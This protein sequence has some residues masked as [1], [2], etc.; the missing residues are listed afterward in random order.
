[1]KTERLHFRID[2]QVK[3][4]FQKACKDNGTTISK[5]VDK[6]ILE[7]INRQP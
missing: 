5:Q 7:Y 4:D 6:M 3:A 1:M 2:P